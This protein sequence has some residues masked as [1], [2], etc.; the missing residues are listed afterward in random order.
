MRRLRLILLPCS[1][2]KYTEIYEKGVSG[3]KKNGNKFY[4][5]IMIPLHLKPRV[6]SWESKPFCG[7]SCGLLQSSLD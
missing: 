5:G 6:K 2:E 7:C 1:K 4:M 3:S